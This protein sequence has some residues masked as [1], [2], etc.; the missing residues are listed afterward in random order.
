MMKEIKLTH[1][2]FTLVDDWNYEY[3]NQW[4]WF[5][6]RSKNKYYAARAVYIDGKRT[7]IYMARV[8]INTP[9]DMEPDHYNHNTL[10]NREYNLINCSHQDNCSNITN[11]RRYKY[12]MKHLVN[13]V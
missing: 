5:A 3:L 7:M 10:D 1:G 11:E 4:K 9:V 12:R 13:R 6:K 2:L 8:I